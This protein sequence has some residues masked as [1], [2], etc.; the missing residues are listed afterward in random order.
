MARVLWLGDAGCTTGFATVTHSI[1]DRLVE[2]YGHDVHVLATNYNGDHWPS[3]MKMYVPTLRASNDIYG[4]MR[5]IELLDKV[6]PEVVISLNDPLV[7]IRHLFKNKYD[8]SFVLGRQ[9]PILAYMPIDG[10]NYPDVINRIPDLVAGLAPLPD[11]RAVKPF[12][13]P[14]V[15][16]KFGNT[17]YPDAPLV[18][19]GVDTERSHR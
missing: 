7:V 15:M 11:A 1:G 18:Y 6:D 13:M 16:S 3:P 12:L 10:A 19:H 4:A 2:R 9:T 17:V 8:Q 14:V 5:F